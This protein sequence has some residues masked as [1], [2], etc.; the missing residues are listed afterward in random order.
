MNTLPQSLLLADARIQLQECAWPTRAFLAY[1]HKHQLDLRAI[2]RFC[3]GY[4]V[5]Q[6]LDL[7]CAR[8]EFASGDDGSLEGFVMEALGEDGETVIDLVAWPT[9][10]P[11]RVM[12]KFGRCGLLGLWQAIGPATYFLGGVLN[13]H[14]TP[15]QWLQSGCEGAAIVTP[16]IAATQLI[17]APGR[18]AA[19][20]HA[21]GRQLVALLR[22]VVDI[23]DKIVVPSKFRR[24]A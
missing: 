5:T 22:T 12:S 8:F 4:G 3:G 16:S 17:E 10:Q 23:E 1:V 2:N 19:R 6:I 14:R 11:E 24:A 20:D 15:L 18:I 9:L 7:G 13:L 21:H